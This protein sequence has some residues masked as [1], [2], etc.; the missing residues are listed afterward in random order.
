M[1]GRAAIAAITLATIVGLVPRTG[2]VG[3]TTDGPSG[4]SAVPATVRAVWTGQGDW[5]APRVRDLVGRAIER[6]A[7][8]LEDGQ[9]IDYRAHAAG[10]IYFL[11][12][13]GPNTERHLVKADQL[14]LQ[15]F[16]RSPDRARQ[17]IVGRREEK[18]LPT[19]IRYHLDHLTVVLD[20]L[21]DRIRLGEGSEVRDVL[22]PAAANALDFYDYRLADSLTLELPDRDVRVYKVEVRPAD[23][24]SAGAVGAIYLDRDMADIVRMEFTF[25]A[26][27]YLD[28]T[29]DYFNIRLE[30]ALWDGKYWLP[31]RQGIELRR[32]IEF[33]D[34]PAGGIIRAE[35]RIS[36]YE[37]NI[38]TPERFFRGPQVSALPADVREAYEFEAGLYDA[39][40]PS[41]AVAPP[42]LEAIREEATRVV[43]RSYLQPSNGFRLAVAGVSSVFRFR[44]AEGFYVGPGVAREYPNG[45]SILWLG[46]YSIAADK[47]QLFGR[48]RTPLAG[49]YDIE[50]SGYLDR[51]ADV[52]PWSASSGVISTLAA[53][54][55]GEDYRDSYWTS[56]GAVSLGRPWGD[57]RAV[58]SAAWERWRPARLEA[59]ANIDRP[60]RDVR[61]VDSGEVAW[62]SLELKRPPVGAVEAV[63]GVSWESRVEA[64]TRSIA[65]DFEYVHLALRG[66]VFWP[67][68]S[69]GTGLRLSGAAGAVAGGAIPAQRLFPVSGRG[70]VRGYRFHD[71]IGN[72]YGAL[73][74]ELSR[75]V[76]YPFVSL[77]LFADAGWVGIE[78]NGARAAVAVW[79]RVGDPAGQARGALLGVGAG[80]GFLFDILW[81]E[82]ARGVVQGGRW[83]V[84][85]RV[86]REFWEWL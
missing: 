32:G 21:G 51:T 74:V 28:E 71:Y 54:V 39:L 50:L 34:F 11:Y 65:G 31:Y 2:L 58:V 80:A 42:S 55:D 47:W 26:A 82:I 33:V 53:L 69:V 10:H 62:F 3:A 68:L 81:L 14:A 59:D 49:A 30:N 48:L 66:E 72:L 61:S 85:V 9:L 57:S 60:Y 67:R 29:L 8:W 16:W 23:P 6:R 83:E 44:R 76:W 7:S 12:D 52:S 24:R 20:N 45:G 15:L 40:D 17:V 84:V 86:R 5:N 25:T 18:A 75:P 35:F 77:D 70:T 64:A 1:T 27:S 73:G 36:D 38:G 56:G 43:A 19:N 41:V 22:H 63:G 78:G 13:L 46:G 4:Q 37:F 79:N